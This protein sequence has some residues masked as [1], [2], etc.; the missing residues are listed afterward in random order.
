[1][2]DNYNNNWYEDDFQNDRASE[3]TYYTEERYIEKRKN[4][5]S[6]KPMMKM[7][8]VILSAALAGSAVAGGVMAL[9]LPDYIERKIAGAEIASQ[10]GETEN[11]TGINIGISSGEAPVT[12][13][14][15]L[16]IPQ[17]AEKV[18]PAIVGIVASIP[19]ATYFGTV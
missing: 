15:V 13:S 14:G 9:T 19:Q 4:S 3:E 12:E 17:I 10:L 11:N 8:A 1:M 2:S 5:G 18:G 16:S 7:L 6:R